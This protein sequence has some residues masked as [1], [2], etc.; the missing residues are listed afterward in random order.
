[1]AARGGGIQGH[2]IRG[3]HVPLQPAAALKAG[4]SGSLWSCTECISDVCR[5]LHLLRNGFD[6]SCRV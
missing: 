5:E 4:V 3:A 1:M 6:P 2:F